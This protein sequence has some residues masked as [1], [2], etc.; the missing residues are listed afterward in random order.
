MTDTVAENVIGQRMP[1]IDATDKVTGRAMYTSDLKLPG[2]LQGAFLRSPHAH[3]RIKSIDISKA[4]K[5]AGVRAVLIQSKLTGRVGKIVDAAHGTSM[6]FQAF[7][8]K[9]VKYQGE[10]IA[11]VAATTK[12][13][14]EE[15][16]RLIHVE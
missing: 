4:E 2:M 12:E 3:A 9:K 14:A 15:A 5:L 10:K 11:A 1:R 16:V 7:A 13:I 6:D 8:D